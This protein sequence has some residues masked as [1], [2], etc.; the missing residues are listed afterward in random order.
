MATT[1]PAANGTA[2]PPPAKPVAG[3]PPSRLAKVNKGRLLG[4]TRYVIYGPEGVG[5][6]T[7]AAAA[8][9]PIF[10]DVEDGSSQID[11]A[12]Y[13]FRDGMAGHVPVKLTEVVAAID[14][15]ITSE[16]SYKTLVIDSVDRL[17][18]LIWK[19]MLA[20]DSIPSARNPKATPMESIEDYG[21]SKG[22]NS[23]V[24]EWR[25]FCA[26]LD[27][28]RYSRNMEIVLVGHAQV[29]TFKNPQG[30]DYDRYQLRINDKAAG[31]LKE[32]AEVT[33]FACF[34]E[35]TAKETKHAR[36]KG[37]STGR[38]LLKLSRSAA[39]D[40]KSRLALPEEVEIDISNPWKPFAEA[41]A[42]ARAV[43]VGAM[44]K[45]ILVELERIGDDEITAKATAAV[46]E[47]VAANDG[48]R[49]QRFLGTL[50]ARPA[51]ETA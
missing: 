40:A 25:S 10:F 14:D 11:V 17:E 36:P 6:T 35:G 48:A 50:Q 49:M 33:A 43:D 42:A 4:P 7:L 9:D 41:V 21:Y 34:E 46:K 24:E 12:R 22:Y 20:R 47:A 39:V 37:F 32:W 23:A 29:K 16:H 27:R 31:F 5:K 30:D 13:P 18:S 45:L 3:P 1:A 15:L 44:E 28:L 51:K 2:L 26:R 19:F 8:P 38:R